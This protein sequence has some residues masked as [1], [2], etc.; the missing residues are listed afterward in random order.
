[1]SN[2][3]LMS[4]E[5]LAKQPGETLTFVMDF[6]ER[7]G[8]GVT[9]TLATATSHTIGGDDSDLDISNIQITGKKIFMLI[10]GGTNSV[11]YVVEVT[12]TL[13]NAEII[14]GAGMLKVTEV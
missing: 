14:I 3:G 7:V 11:Q 12:C 2:C 8:T 10:S 5:L 6:T 13:N 9:I 1:M 4:K